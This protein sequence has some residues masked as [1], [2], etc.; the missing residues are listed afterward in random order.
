M[1]T[2]M[3][4][5][6]PAWVARVGW[7]LVHFVWQGALL[8]GVW[9]LLRWFLLRRA[10]GARYLAACGVLFL[11]AVAPVVTWVRLGP[12]V[13]SAGPRT[14]RAETPPT[15]AQAMVDRFDWPFGSAVSLPGASIWATNLERGMGWLVA[16]WALGVGGLSIR[17]LRG[18]RI[19]DRLG[20]S[21]VT[22]PEAAWRH[23]LEELRGRLRVSRPVQLLQS[24]WVEVPTVAGW[25]RPVILLPA[26]SLAGLSPGQLELVLAH[27]L[28]HIR[29]WDDWVNLG[30]VLL[31][32]LL[33][34]HPGVWWVSRCIREEREFCCDDLAVEACGDRL[35]YAEALTALEI[36]RGEWPA[37][38]MAATGGSLLHR[39]RRV[40][41]LPGRQEG[42]RPP[43]NAL[44]G[45]G[46][47]LLA[48]GVACLALSPVRYQAVA[49]VVVLREPEVQARDPRV[50]VFDPYF[51]QT[52]CER[53]K[54]RR[55]LA[56]V[57]TK[58]SLA[59]RWGVPGGPGTI[60]TERAVS[61]LQ[62]MIDVGQIRSTSLVEIRVASRE[63]DEAAA[64]ANALAEAYRAERVALKKRGP[65]AGLA[66][67]RERLQEQEGS[68]RAL[69]DRV[70]DLRRDPGLSDALA[71]A[72]AKPSGG[73]D[74]GAVRRLEAERVR[75]QAQR[76]GSAALLEQLRELNVRGDPGTAAALLEAV[77][78]AESSRLLVEIW[79]VEAQLARERVAS[80][81]DHPN[82]RGLEAMRADLQ[83]KLK[84]RLDAMLRGLEVKLAAQKAEAESL[85]QAVDEA[86]RREADSAARSGPYLQAQRDLAE[87]QKIR[88]AILLRLLQET[89]DV[90]IPT[91]SGV[92]IV[93]RAE[94]PWRRVRLWHLP[95]LALCG[96]GILL[97]LAGLIQ[98][99][100]G[101]PGAMV[102]APA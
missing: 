40:L 72:G 83:Q 86:K 87:T 80:S 37:L 90:N 85:T 42:Y 20:R 46:L 84:T 12:A 30:Q 55:L 96:L 57:A 27:E 95:G 78:N 17:L 100:K 43:G 61:R 51:I 7:V 88:D 73:G 58:M 99:R 76:S 65:E 33:F 92:E 28:A 101:R 98:K 26:S 49:R 50:A 4:L 68:V 59:D 71:E 39:V 64:I 45:A 18:W 22:P 91:E 97:A 75:V 77:P 11:M 41:G 93:D 23:R 66:R 69:Q 2:S 36:L 8:A 70:Q 74:G 44:L 24:A 13:D 1:M 54:S 21:A 81:E 6:H 32:T 48:A 53:L 3:E 29:R 102:T 16:C 47:V 9:A 79:L 67:L 38:L 19:V 82:V 35:A 62:R 94:P 34:Y 60:A 5:L 56:D 14:A 31:E 15:G 89:V 52:E 10:A 63:A 25:L